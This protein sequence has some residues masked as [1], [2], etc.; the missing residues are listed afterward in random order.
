MLRLG[1]QIP[2]PLRSW[3]ES[4]IPEVI[5]DVIAQVGY[6]E[7]SPIQRQAIPIGLMNRDVIGVAET[8]MLCS[9]PRISMVTDVC[10]T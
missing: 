8:G 10:D 9:L 1:G 6:T 2:L 5:L 4:S 3:Q 7:P